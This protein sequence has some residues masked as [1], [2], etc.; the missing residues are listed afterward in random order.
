MIN[1]VQSADQIKLTYSIF[2]RT[3]SIKSLKRYS[4]TGKAEKNL[5][6]L[7][8][9]TNASNEDILNIL[10]QNYNKIKNVFKYLYN[11]CKIYKV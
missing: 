7:L 11:K 9:A 5:E 3:I 1:K 6:R 10:N 4:L 8:K 2:S